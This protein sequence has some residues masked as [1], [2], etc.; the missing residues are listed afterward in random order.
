[1]DRFQS[2]EN[3]MNCDI[4]GGARVR[5]LISYTV[6]YRGKPIVVE[7]VPADVCQQCG[8]QYFDPATVAMLQK[9]VW[10]K[11]KPKRTIKTPV[12]DLAA[13]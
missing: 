4:C 1:M 9:V 6:F 7:N 5:S 8:E 10:G 3:K 12:Y 13:L 2:E 11:S